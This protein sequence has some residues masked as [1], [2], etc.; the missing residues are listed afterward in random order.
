[1]GRVLR[2]FG[3]VL[4]AA[5]AALVIVATIDIISQR[6][7][8]PAE[9]AAILQNADPAERALPEARVEQLLAVE[10]PTFF[11]RQGIDLATPGQGLT[12]IGQGLGKRI[13]FEPFSPGWRKIRL[14]YLTRFA[15]FPTSSREDILTAFIAGAYL[16]NSEGEPVIGFAQGAETWFGAP[17]DALD[18]DAWLG[19][20]AMLISPNVLRPTSEP[21]AHDQRVARIKKLL[22]EDCAPNGLRDVW[23]EGC[24]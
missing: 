2:W 18:D 14:M 13:Y 6:A 12:T 4:L 11:E 9:I 19:L 7:S 22:A 17:L 20:V 15:M 24:A 23:L 1:M 8:T 5:I 3:G 10:D 21:D 16:G